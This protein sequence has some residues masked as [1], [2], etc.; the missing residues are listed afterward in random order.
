MKSQ[1]C[2]R[3]TDAP[4]ELLFRILDAAGCAKTREDQLRREHPVY[5]HEFEKGIEDD[6]G[7]FE[8]LLRTA[9][10][11]SFQHYNKINSK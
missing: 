10:N 6:R 9:T 8:N 1:V 11:L 5:S 2:I 4:H 7:I 3:K